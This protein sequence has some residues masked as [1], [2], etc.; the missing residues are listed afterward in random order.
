LFRF[1]LGY[2]FQN[3]MPPVNH[4]KIRAE[5][6]FSV[7]YKKY[8]DKP[9]PAP[10]PL[11]IASAKHQ[12]KMKTLINITAIRP[13]GK[14]QTESQFSFVRPRSAKK[15]TYAG[16]ARMIAAKLNAENDGDYPMVKPSEISVSRIEALCYACS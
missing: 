5:N 16:A 7:P 6:L 2:C 13:L 14:N 12:T 4:Q 15:P 3:Q 9:N 10:Y 8:I 1:N 11:R